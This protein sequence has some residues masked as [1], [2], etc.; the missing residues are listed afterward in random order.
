MM[1]EYLS[2]LSERV[3]GEPIL[4]VLDV[5]PAHRTSKMQERAQEFHIELVFV[6]AGGTFVCQPLDRRAFGELK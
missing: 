3:Q 6:P 4:V 1:P 5:Y 2:W